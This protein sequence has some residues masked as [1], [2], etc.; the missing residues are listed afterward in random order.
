MVDDTNC[1][2][3]KSSTWLQDTTQEYYK[4]KTWEIFSPCPGVFLPQ[5]GLNLPFCHGV[6]CTGDC[7]MVAVVKKDKFQNLQL[8]KF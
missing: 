8:G 1:V 4:G 5:Q 2:R 7:S 3:S 6:N